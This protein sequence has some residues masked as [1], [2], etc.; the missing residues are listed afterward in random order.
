MAK[1][2][3]LRALERAATAGPW[4]VSAEYTSGR[5]VPLSDDLRVI[6]VMAQTGDVAYIA[7]AL[8]AR[9]EQE[10]NAA[11]IVASRAALPALLKVAEAAQKAID[12]FGYILEV[13]HNKECNDVDDVLYPSML[14]ECATRREELRKAMFE[15][16]AQ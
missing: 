7:N 6:V 15:L 2:E 11:Y 1:L 8:D 13:A 5:I 10:A 3:Q 16:E 4:D 12:Q 14:A 9:G